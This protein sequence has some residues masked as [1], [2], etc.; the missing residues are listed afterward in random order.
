[1]GLEYVPSQ[2]NFVLVRVGDGDEIF[3]TLLA[4][5]IIV[6]A[7]ASYQLPEWIRVSVGTEPQNRRFIAEL[8]KVLA[9][10]PVAA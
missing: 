3:K 8:R 1:M 10:A 2:A 9:G 5:G 4:Q 6:R 7:M